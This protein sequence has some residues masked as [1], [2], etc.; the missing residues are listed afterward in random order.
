MPRA[1]PRS[2]RELDHRARSDAPAAFFVM[3]G[4]PTPPSVLPTIPHAVGLIAGVAT[5]LAVS[6]KITT[7]VVFVPPGLVAW[8]TQRGRGRKLDFGPFALAALAAAVAFALTLPLRPSDLAARHPQSALRE[9]RAGAVAAA[10]SAELGMDVVVALPGALAG[11]PSSSRSWAWSRR[12]GCPAQGEAVSPIL[13]AFP[14]LYWLGI[15]VFSNLRWDHWLVP[16]LP[17]VALW[18]A[19]GCRP[20]TRALA[21][22]AAGRSNETESICVHQ[23]LEVVKRM[24]LSLSLAA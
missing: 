14:L 5:G 7:G 2:Y 11:R 3:L 24:A 21:W 13:L 12:A 10:R 23:A 9:P 16:A 6:M 8:I 18:S 1:K 4:I 15:G 17:V 19:A 22:A 20:V